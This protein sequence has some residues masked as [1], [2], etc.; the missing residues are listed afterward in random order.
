MRKR[1]W[2]WSPDQVEK[3]V[4]IYEHKSQHE[5]MNEFPG[6]PW[7]NI[8]TKA[9]SLG[10]KRNNVFK[11]G[12][13]R[14]QVIDLTEID[15][16]VKSYI[17][18]FISADGALCKMVG[19]RTP[20]LL[21]KLSKKDLN[22]LKTLRDLISPESKIRYVPRDDMFEFSIADPLL[23]TQLQYHGIVVRKTYNP[24]IPKTVPK[25]LVASWIRGYFDGDGC[26]TFGKSQNFPDCFI[27]GY[28]LANGSNPI[29][30]FINEEFR[31]IYPH[32]CNV[33]LNKKRLSTIHYGG[34]TAVIFL[35]WLY[36]FATIYMDRK[37]ALA[38]KFLVVD[39]D[40]YIKSIKSRYWTN[41]EVDYLKQNIGLR[42]LSEMSIG[43]GR[44]KTQISSK[45][46]DL[47]RDGLL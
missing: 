11:N 35:N 30:K 6:R 23:A 37:Y 42:T 14:K 21:I 12:V 34:H 7:K 47:K 39:L 20:S 41:E 16:E 27:G 26:I 40:D 10:L 2:G 28:T 3:L 36:N 13:E 15:T 5:V 25:H 4:A 44:S 17:V 46:H 33:T 32:N 19:D 18:G 38:E 1:I 8:W 29:I 22:H 43:L 31:K 45:T 9:T 24:K